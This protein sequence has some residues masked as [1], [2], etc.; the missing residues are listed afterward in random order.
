MPGF[1]NHKYDRPHLVR[2][3]PHAAIAGFVYRPEQFP[4]LPKSDRLASG[5]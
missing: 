4:K 2:V 5:R 3:E 1:Y